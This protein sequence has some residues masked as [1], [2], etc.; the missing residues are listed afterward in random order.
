[1]NW[2]V[3][4]ATEDTVE[5]H[6]VAGIKR[7]RGLTVKIRFMRG[8]PDRLCLLPGGRLVW[9]ELKRPVGGQFEPLQLRIHAKLRALG[10]RVAVC[11]TKALVDQLLEDFT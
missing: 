1:M 5:D 10:F 11:H 6:L 7:L 2:R 4:T 3:K 9:V 8:W